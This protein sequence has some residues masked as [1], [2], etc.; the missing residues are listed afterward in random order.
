[1]SEIAR[2]KRLVHVGCR[3]LGLDPDTRRGLQ[4]VACGKGSL[5]QM[6]EADLHKVVSELKARGFRPKQGGR[7]PMAK[8]ADV[9]F[10]HVLWKLLYEAGKVREPGA[11]GLNKFIRSRFEKTWCA[12][13]IDIDAMDDWRQINDVVQALK[14]WCAREDVELD[15]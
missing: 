14:D 8:R 13:P 4:V 12:V 10:C 11:K 6:D 15:K 9:R 5:T 1:M 2:L 3:D 7:R